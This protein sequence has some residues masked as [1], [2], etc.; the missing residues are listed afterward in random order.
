APDVYYL[1]K[2]HP[3]SFLYRNLNLF[4]LYLK[5]GMSTVLFSG[6]ISLTVP[7]IIIFKSVFLRFTG[8]LSNSEFDFFQLFLLILSILVVSVFFS[9]LRFGDFSLW[10]FVY[11]TLPG[12]D[13]IR[14][15]S[16]IIAVLIFPSAILTAALVDRIRAIPAAGIYLSWL[17]SFMVVIE[18][19]HFY[20]YTYSKND[21][22]F[23]VAEIEN[24]LTNSGCSVFHYRNPKYVSLF[25]DVDAMWASLR[26]GIPTVNGYSGGIPPGWKLNDRSIVEKKDIK[27]W[28]AKN[29]VVV[30]DKK[31]CI[32]SE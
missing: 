10:Y 3:G 7:L 18:N 32:F 6:L 1:L 24:R 26:T 20:N 13:A 4:S 15:V 11:H 22:R 28:L 12:A 23:L 16:R 8:K 2:P 17:L 21:H 29:Q 14:A 30:P 19:S 5:T 9:F 31:I 27:E 25:S